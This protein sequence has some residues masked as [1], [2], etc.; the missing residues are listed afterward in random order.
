MG[1]DAGGVGRLAYFVSPHGFGHAARACA[2]MQAMRAVWPRVV[3]E[4]FTLVPEWFFA[5]SLE[6]GSATTSCARMSGLCS[7][8]RSRRIPRPRLG[9]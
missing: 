6:V 3:F 8:R 1:G 2:V 5:E 9:F 7:G 4:V